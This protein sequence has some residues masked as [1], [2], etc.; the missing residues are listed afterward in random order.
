MNKILKKASWTL[1]NQ[2]SIRNGMCLWS[3]NGIILLEK[4]NN[5]NNINTN[6][7]LVSYD[8]IKIV[9]LTILLQGFSG[10][11][12]CAVRLLLRRPRFV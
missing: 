4:S 7:I 8:I 10:H 9:K 5:N 12:L 3:L 6:K 1:F 2:L 11:L